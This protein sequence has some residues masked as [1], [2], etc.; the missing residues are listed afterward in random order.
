MLTSGEL[1]IDDLFEQVLDPRRGQHT[2]A[3][4]ARGH[5]GAAQTRRLDGPDV[6]DRARIRLHAVLTDHLLHDPVLAVTKPDD[7]LRA[8]R[9]AWTPCGQFDP[10]RGKE[11]AHPVI[12]WPP[13]DVLVVITN[14]VERD[15]LLAALI[16]PLAQVLVKHRLPGGG[17]HLCR[18]GQHPIQIKQ[19]C[20]HTSR[21]A[22]H[23]P[24]CTP[25]QGA[26]AQRRARPSGAQISMTEPVPAIWSA[27]GSSNQTPPVAR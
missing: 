22:K 21:Q 23:E 15:E 1:P 14:R 4:G 19:A 27:A 20:M 8:Q 6:A 11:R 26:Q 5:D 16:C 7:R 9:V 24:D 18:L 3:V 17:M 10:P 13:V 2:A 12:P 25:V